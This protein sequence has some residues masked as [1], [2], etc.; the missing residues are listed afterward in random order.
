MAAL[1]LQAYPSGVGRGGS[2]F[3]FVG[4]DAEDQVRIAFLIDEVWPDAAGPGADVFEE[5]LKALD[6]AR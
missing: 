2:A 5:L 1:A 6:A 3:P 4:H